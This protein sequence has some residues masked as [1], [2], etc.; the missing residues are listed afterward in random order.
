M[1]TFVISQSP[2]QNMIHFIY[3]NS[4][5]FHH[6]V[7]YELTK[8]CSPVGLISSVDRGLHLVIAKSEFDAQSSLNFFSFFFD[9]LG[10]SF[11][12]EDHVHF[13]IGQNI[14]DIN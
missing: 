11:Y 14:A 10:C 8:A 12:C 9:C 3:F 6:W 13:H 2:V 5:H 7:Y 4:Y 1:L